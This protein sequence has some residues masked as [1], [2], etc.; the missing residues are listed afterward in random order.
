MA[1]CFY[2]VFVSPILYTFLELFFLIFLLYGSS[3]I[4]K[5]REGII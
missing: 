5:D 4:L 1:R 3:L 2:K